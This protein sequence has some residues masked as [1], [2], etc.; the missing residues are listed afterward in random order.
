MSGVTPFESLVQG[1]S[2]RFRGALQRALFVAQL[3]IHHSTIQLS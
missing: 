2:E 1:G 3:E